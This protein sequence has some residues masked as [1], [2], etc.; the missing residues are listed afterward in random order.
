MA[1]SSA[2]VGHPKAAPG[3]AALPTDVMS[4]SVRPADGDRE[5]RVALRLA[6]AAVV[7][8]VGSVALCYVTERSGPHRPNGSGLTSY[9][10]PAPF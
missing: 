2:S 9:V 4:S 1:G 3:A 10:Q 5:Q 8:T 7:L 6:A